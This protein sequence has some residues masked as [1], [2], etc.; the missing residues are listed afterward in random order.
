MQDD[1]LRDD[2][3]DDGFPTY[4]TPCKK[5]SSTSWGLIGDI[6]AGVG[7]LSVLV[8]CGIGW[9]AVQFATDIMAEEVRIELEENAII[10]EKIGNIQTMSMDMAKSVAAQGDDEWVF[11]IEGDKGSGYVTVESFTNDAGFEVVTSGS[12]RMDSGE[13]F[14]LDVQDG[15]VEGDQAEEVEDDAE[16]ADE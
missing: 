12:L 16:G 3:D 14:P 11:R 7:L 4:D 1:Y 10:Q 9:Y 2:L 13:T 6:L 15:L 8:C 5:R